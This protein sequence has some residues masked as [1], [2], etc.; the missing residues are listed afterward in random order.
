MLVGPWNGKGW[1]TYVTAIRNMLRSF[2]W[3]TFGI[4]YGHLVCFTVILVYFI[5]LLVFFRPFWY[6][7]PRKIWQPCDRIG[8]FKNASFHF[9]AQSCAL[10]AASETVL[11]TDRSKKTL[12][13]GDT[14]AL[15][16]PNPEAVFGRKCFVKIRFCEFSAEKRTQ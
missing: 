16:E 1:F 11:E 8:Q 7:V 6:V 10:F 5:I 13:P 12:H 15:Q 3:W 2:D 4:F 9:P 14:R